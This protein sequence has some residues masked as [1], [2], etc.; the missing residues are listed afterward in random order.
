MLS[1]R[2][3]APRDVLRRSSTRDRRA[4]RKDQVPELVPDGACRAAGPPRRGSILA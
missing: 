1:L 4:Q 2:A 3:V